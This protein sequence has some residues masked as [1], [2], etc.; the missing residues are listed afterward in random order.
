MKLS[1]MNIYLALSL[2]VCSSQGSAS[3]PELSYRGR[4]STG[5]P[6]FLFLDKKDA[7]TPYQLFITSFGVLS[8]DAVKF[9]ADVRG[10]ISGN[11][12]EGARVLTDKVTWPN[13][14]L[15][16]PQEVFGD[17]CFTI[18]GGFLVPTK[19]TGMIGLYDKNQKTLVSLTKSKSGYFY[20][21][22]VW[23][24]MNGD[25]KLDI[26]TAR[27]TRPIFGT[28]GGELI[29][30]EQPKDSRQVPWREHVITKGPDVN[31]VYE[32]IDGDGANEII[33]AQFFTKRLAILWK[34]GVAWKTRI[35]DD[36]I[37][38]PFDVQLIDLNHDGK[39]EIL[40]T[41][42]ENVE[43][44]SGVFA[45]EIPS[46][47]KHA[48]FRK[49]VIL[50]GIKTLEPGFGKGSPGRA[51]AFYPY[52]DDLGNKPYIAVSGDGAQKAF[53]LMPATDRTDDFTY[54]PQVIMSV[55]KGPVG[56]IAISDVDGDGKAEI[57]IP[58]YGEDRIDI[59]TV[60][61]NGNGS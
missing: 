24:D 44:A 26:L 56:Q 30:L 57:F 7:D 34:D 35:I 43:S 29:W 47:I 19:S 5:S 32:D 45:Y 37:G 33:A 53:M 23:A 20:H 1:I 16:A 48:A 4:I 6:G 2:F 14:I 61:G 41:N 38:S 46:D 10:Y 12:A 40:V 58:A 51:A 8:G 13:E 42:H 9:V 22:V 52:S 59:F 39:K 18:A 31:F 3:P 36:A 55:S 60:N 28:A 54:I 17:D 15:R 50:Q 49:H 25:G 27:A 21:R 11:Y